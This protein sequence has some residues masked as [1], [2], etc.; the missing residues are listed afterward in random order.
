MALSAEKRTLFLIVVLLLGGIACM[1]LASFI[2]VMR[3]EALKHKTRPLAVLSAEQSSALR[4]RKARLAS[5]V[6][7]SVPQNGSLTD[8]ITEDVS[9]G[10]TGGISLDVGKIR[11][12]IKDQGGDST[13]VYF[14]ITIDGEAAGR[15]TFKLYTDTAPRT[16]ENFRALATGE[17][18]ANEEGVVLSYAGTI[19]HRII[20]GFVC[21]GGR[22]G[23]DE[24]PTSIYG[25]SFEDEPFIHKHYKK[26]LLSMAN[27]GK[28]T[29]GSQFFITMSAQPSL[30]GKHVVFGELL[31]ESL[32]LLDRINTL[33]TG[34]GPSSTVAVAQSGQL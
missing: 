10:V 32:P 14:D 12:I 2:Q 6:V 31:E 16:A 22:F 11:D 17:K 30:D 3:E 8:S 18:G 1:N 26:G 15:L 13:L 9:G 23:A 19:F 7:T 28:D 27:M 20:P 21:Q 25:A 29:N 24:K 34:R 4:T 33:G 5:R